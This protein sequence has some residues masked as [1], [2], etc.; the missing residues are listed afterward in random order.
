[1]TIMKINSVK[2]NETGTGASARARSQGLIPGVLYGKD[3][4][5][6]SLNFKRKDIESVIRRLGENAVIDVVL[7]EKSS[8]RAIIKEIQRGIIGYEVIH[9]DLQKIDRYQKLKVF[10][11]VM[12]I[13]TDFGIDGGI[14]EQH[15]DE[16]EVQT[17]PVDMPRAF[18]LDVSD[19]D[20]G[21]VLTVSDIEK[22]AGVEILHSPDDTVVAITPKQMVSEDESVPDPLQIK[23]M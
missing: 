21:D 9:L 19:L 14:I 16:I 17:T 11:P 12:L 10:V 5:V 8:E 7:D 2:R 4:D 15:L 13:G 1:M 22:I 6:Q 20:V 23:E 18:S 3:L